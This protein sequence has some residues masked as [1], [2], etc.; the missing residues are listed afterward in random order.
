MEIVC[1]HCGQAY[2]A[3]EAYL[4]QTIECQT[5]GKSF[6]AEIQEDKQTIPLSS[7]KDSNEKSNAEQPEKQQTISPSAIKN[8]KE[9]ES[10]PLPPKPK[11][12][13]KEKE[14]KY[15][16][17][18]FIRGDSSEFLPGFKVPIEARVFCILKIL[19]AFFGTIQA[20]ISL[21]EGAVFFV[22][23]FSVFVAYF[24]LSLGEKTITYLAEIAYNTRI[25][26]K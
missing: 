24:S 5:C 11:N 7:I 21:E 22:Q 18:Y 3:D 8:S 10:F 19:V 15:V 1:P 2:D 20:F 6:V 9:E 12:P 13:E 17:D 25:K 16:W 14:E 23:Q 26:N 4:G